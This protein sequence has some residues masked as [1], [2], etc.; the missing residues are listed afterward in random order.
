MILLR[1]FDGYPQ[2]FTHSAKPVEKPLTPV[3]NLKNIPRRFDWNIQVET[4]SEY[5]IFSACRS[6][7]FIN[8]V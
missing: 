3:E 1:S 7:Y 8:F 5:Q 4:G 2:I 6:E